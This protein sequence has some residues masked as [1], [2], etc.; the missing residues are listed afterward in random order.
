MFFVAVTEPCCVRQD[1][2]GTQTPDNL[3]VCR[4]FVFFFSTNKM[5]SCAKLIC[6]PIE[7]LYSFNIQ[8]TQYLYITHYI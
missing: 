5:L 1:V 6:A 7:I 2:S 3:C 4:L 8:L